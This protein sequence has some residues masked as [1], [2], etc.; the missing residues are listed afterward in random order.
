[1]FT[2]QLQESEHTAHGARVKICKLCGAL[3]K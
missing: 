2:V 1:M 3:L